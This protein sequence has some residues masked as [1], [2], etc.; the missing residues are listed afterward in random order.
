M[1]FPASVLVFS[2]LVLGLNAL[3]LRE[4]M[5]TELHFGGTQVWPRASADAFSVYNLFFASFTIITIP[6]VCALSQ[7]P[8]LA[9]DY[10]QQQGARLSTSP[11]TGVPL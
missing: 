1:I 6:L 5:H 8:W 10:Q 7:L 4:T 2:I 3:Y 9:H 11:G